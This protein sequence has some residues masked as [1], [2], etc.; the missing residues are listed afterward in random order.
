MNVCF[1]DIK[2]YSHIFDRIVHLLQD[3]IRNMCS[4]NMHFVLNDRMQ[5]ESED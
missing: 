1:Q 5:E 4:D 3:D 2:T